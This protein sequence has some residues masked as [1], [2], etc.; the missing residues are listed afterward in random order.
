M[1]S[2]SLN[3]IFKKRNISLGDRIRV[4]KGDQ[5]FEGLLM[6][7]AKES[8]ILVVK[9]DTGYNIGIDSKNTVI[10]LIEKHKEFKEKEEEFK[11]GDIAIFGCGGT[12]AS[13][14]EYRTGA[15][16]PLIKPKELLTIFPEISK[17]STIHAKNLFSI[18]S[19][20]I[21]HEHWK[22]IAKE[23]YNEIKDGVKGVVL[24]QGTDTLHYT[25]AALSFM[26]QDL[27][28][29]VV[30]VGAQR[31][32]DRPSS[33]NR[34]NLINSVYSCKQNI[35][36]VG[37]CMHAETSDNYCH[38]HK[39]TKVRKMHTSRRDAFKPINSKPFAIVD[40]YNKKFEPLAKFRKRSKSTP[41]L[42]TK[43]N[44]NV[45]LIYFHPGMKPKFIDSLREYDGV[46]LATTGLG[47]LSTNPFKDKLAKPILSNVKSLIDSGIPVVL[48]PQTIYGRLNLNVYSAGR[49]T[50]E[51][52]VIGDGADW[53]P[54]TAFVKLC[55][56]LGHEKKMNKIEEMMMKNLAGEISERSTLKDD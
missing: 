47:Q 53:T 4:K 23:T 40:Y 55:F 16:Y 19:E 35:A 21:S 52:G 20:D 48:A 25:S 7:R 37:V 1:Y 8:H 18:F 41:K 27:P 54:E 15:V 5:I 28:V 26:L 3:S 42:D 22:V 45:A 31:S 10:S 33:D 49:L 6:P 39:G 13:K 46:V 24:M 9:L 38:L 43:L 30:L 12:I 50:K 32:S 11:S 56:V 29:P 2:D 36:E 51:A 34:L 14:I 17:I 44:S